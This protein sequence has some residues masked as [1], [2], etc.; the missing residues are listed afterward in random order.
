MPAWTGFKSRA[1]VPF[2]SS[3]RIAHQPVDRVSAASDAWGRR[4]S[5]I[6]SPWQL[7]LHLPRQR[8]APEPQPIPIEVVIEVPRVIVPPAPSAPKGTGVEAPRVAPGETVPAGAAAPIQPTRATPVTTAAE[9]AANWHP[10]P[11]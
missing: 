7:A 2:R 9:P 6:C 3:S 5:C 4:S 8:L 10:S 11:R 1:V